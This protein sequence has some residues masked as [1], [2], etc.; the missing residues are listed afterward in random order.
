M[1]LSIITVITQKNGWVSLEQLSGR[2][3][4]VEISHEFLW[5][6]R[7]HKFGPILPRDGVTLMSQIP[8]KQDVFGIWYNSQN[9]P[10]KFHTY[11]PWNLHMEKEYWKTSFLGAILVSDSFRE[12]VCWDDLF[13]SEL[14]KLVEQFLDFNQEIW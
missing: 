4:D 8:W 6:F 13:T 7:R 2:I 3:P 9:L 11:P 12:A 5:I 10:T 14:G 1:V